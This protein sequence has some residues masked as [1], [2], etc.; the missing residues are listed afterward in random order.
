M[1]TGLTVCVFISFQRPRLAKC[2]WFVC[3]TFSRFTGPEKLVSF[4]HSLQINLDGE[5]LVKYYI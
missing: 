2:M 1:T 4:S 3:F 5:S